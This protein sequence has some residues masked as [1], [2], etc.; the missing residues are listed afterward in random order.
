[1]NIE[2]IMARARSALICGYEPE[3][4]QVLLAALPVVEAAR[5]AN[6]EPLYME[7]DMALAAF[8]KAIAE[9]RA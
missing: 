8:D 3:I 2:E 9:I 7:L 4:A 5:L 6:E 1:M